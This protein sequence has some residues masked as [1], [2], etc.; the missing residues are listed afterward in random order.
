MPAPSRRYRASA[1]RY[2]L[3]ALS[4]ALIAGASPARAE[5]GLVDVNQLP[6]LPG[7]QETTDS[8][9]D[10]VIYTVQGVVPSAVRSVQTL[11]TDN[12]WMRYVRPLEETTSG[13]L[14]KKGGYGLSVSF[15][16]ALGRPDR[17]AVYYAANRIY[18]DVPFPLGATDI[19]YDERRPYFGC[20][21]PGSIDANLDFFNRELAAAGWTPLSADD[22]RT[23]W[24]DAAIDDKIDNGARAYFRRDDRDRQSPIMVS[25]RR[26]GDD[27]TAVD[28]RVAPFAL[29]QDLRAG[30]DMDGLP[31]PDRIVTAGTTGNAASEHR[32]AHATVVAEMPAVLAF[33]RREL[34]ARGWKEETKGAV[35]TPD[36]AS[37]NFTAPEETGRLKLGRKYDLT[38]VSFVLQVT[39][40]ALAARA[41][42]KKQADDDFMKD[43]M[44]MATELIA[45][46][47]AR[48]AQQST[49]LSDA[50]LHARAGKTTPIPVPEGAENVEFDGSD[51]KLEFESASSVKTLAGFY[52]G[53]LKPL[54]WKTQPTVINNP[55]M[56][57]LQ[58]SKGGKS[59]SITIM[60][61]GAK[62]NVSANGSGLEMA[63]AGTNAASDDQAAAP[64]AA[65][66]LEAEPDSA[67]PVPKDHTLSSITTG[68]LPGSDAP[69][70]RELEASIPADLA[71]V[72]AFYRAELEKR[73]WKEATDHAITKP[74][75]AELAFASPD[76]PAVLKLGRQKNE[77]TVNLAQKIPA[78]AAKGDVLPKP[79]QSRLM[80]G[81][82]GPTDATIT[83]N[84]RTIK[85]VAGAGG[86]QSSQHPA[87]DLPP[88]KY[89]YVTK[90][91][92]RTGKSGQI[93][94]GADDA[95]GLMLGPD[96]DVLALQA[97]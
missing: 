33:Y 27:K 43:A 67:L 28:I 81:N 22:A 30:P 55:N 60:Q 77:T 89:K 13:L 1:R 34:A 83:I 19:I 37:L 93:E 70:R 76:G 14:F 16:Q 74:D 47:N 52:R 90:V 51:G 73:G 82:M 65:K 48:R 57:A 5:S 23:R 79:G 75:R 97:Y 35:V 36:E 3:T 88:G 63:D 87:L 59:I 45:A 42:A 11:L 24:P 56:A 46:D 8:Q 40:S 49:T 9:P 17:S 94:L 78:A 84:K 54:G 25:L 96:G 18:A 58:F 12:G 64:A 80:L 85:L 39:P 21:A 86:P 61:M 69:F 50:P 91:A 20:T 44:S 66:P 10:R 68:A 7:A 62:T 38:L 26:L 71:S 95:W 2:V 6:R 72:L 15:T 29:P 92:G 53:A 41:R 31:R 32:E 4:L